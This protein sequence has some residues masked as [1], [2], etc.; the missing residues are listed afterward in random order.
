[1]ST[2]SG[3]GAVTVSG[4]AAGNRRVAIH[5]LGAGDKIK[6]RFSGGGVTYEGHE[7]NG[8][9][10]SVD[11]KRLVP[12]DSL[13]T[14]DV[15]MVD[16]VNYLYN[17]VVLK[18][19]SKASI[20]GIYINAE[21]T[22]KVSMP[23]LVDKGSNTVQITAGQST[24][25]NPVITCYTTDGSEPTRTNGTSGPYEEFDVQLLQGGIVTIK[26][27]SYTE[28]GVYSKMAELTIFAD[29]LIGG[30]SRKS[31]TRVAAGT[32]DMQG[33]KVQSVRH[34]KLYIKD[35]KVVFFE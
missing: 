30:N 34:G 10:I 33:N 13:R 27:V 1:M 7:T 15:I 9:I 25:G 31:N 29:D 22:D 17:Y 6:L 24:M 19:D 26:A 28:G 4:L 14:G 23:T 18:L 35:G 2:E 11:G 12:G 21:E 16:K 8:N 20:N 5:N 3:E 32:Y